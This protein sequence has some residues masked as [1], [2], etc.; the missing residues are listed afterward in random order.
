MEFRGTVPFVL[1]GTIEQDGHVGCKCMGGT[2]RIPWDSPAFPTGANGTG[3]TR[4]MQVYG[5]DL[6]DCVGQSRLSYTGQWD[7]MD[8]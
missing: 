1:H 3:R 2:Y 8:M 4:R 5:R 7:R 6:W